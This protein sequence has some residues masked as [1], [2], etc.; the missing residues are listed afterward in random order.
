MASLAKNDLERR[1]TCANRANR[2]DVSGLV[3]T[4]ITDRLA[5]VVFV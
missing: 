2:L 4:E 3:C 5:M 1:V